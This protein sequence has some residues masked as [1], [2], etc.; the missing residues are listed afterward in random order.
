[1]RLILIR[2]GQ[3]EASSA[4]GS[5]FRRALT[6]AGRE[7]LEN[8][9]PSLARYLNAKASCEV[10]TSPKTRALQTAEVLCRYMPDVSPEI[11]PFLENGDLDAFADA[12]RS[13]KHGDT[14]VVI[15]HEPYLSDWV[16]AMTGLDVHFKKGCGEML[17]LPP[18]APERA[19]RIAGIDFDQMKTLDLFS[20]PVGVGI[21]T[22]IERQHKQIVK[23]RD[24]FL[25]D[26]DDSDALSALRVALRSQYALLE[27][28]EPYCS[29]KP[30]R[31]AERLYLSLYDD[32]EE[33]RAIN[34]ILK[35][36]HNSRKLELAVLADAIRSHKHGD[37][38]V[39]IGHEPY[40]SDWV[41][42]MT[43]LDVH[44]K[45][46]CGEM[47]Y[48][49]PHAPERAIRIAGIDFDQM[50]TLDLF[51]VP[52]GVGIATLIERQ[53]KQIVKARDTFLDDPDDSDAL[54][55][56][57]VALRSQY[58][59]LEFIE[60]YCSQKPFRKAERLY[61]SLYD[62]LEE[63]RA[64]NAIL[65]TIHNSRKLELAV[66]ADAMVVEQNDALM[67]LCD[68]LSREDSEEDYNEALHQTIAVLM[69]AKETAPLEILVREQLSHRYRLVLDAI[70]A[71][72]FNDLDAIEHL[73]SLCK[74][75]RY[76]FE[77]FSPLADYQLAQQYLRIRRLNQRLSIYC[78]TFY[79]I[80]QLQERLSE[81][82]N[83]LV[84]RAMRL[85]TQMMR[86]S[87]QA[88]MEVVE[89]LIDEFGCNDAIDDEEELPAKKKA[90]KKKAQK[91]PKEKKK[92]GK[93][94]EKKKQ[95]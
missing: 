8:A 6:P 29:Q 35:T 49:P 38:L 37:T 67:T 82:D 7:R 74:T 34:A 44:F 13:H 61:L 40:L 86:Q 70:C 36:I 45:K 93:K 83:P 25:D 5:D 56:L 80:D 27:F 69:T 75:S 71:T 16:R 87:G 60:P 89:R 90:D 94:K 9:Y 63:L 48:L 20:V 62:D 50:K 26:P 76:L 19:I 39:V 73:R 14:L 33:L 24:T 31:K 15:G 78:D 92:D 18:H 65:K 66:L 72:D 32:L 59:L 58:A 68:H 64:I 23:A 41:R 79:N 30:F 43:G 1:M 51:S 91:P 81:D 52:V 12:I 47:L 3:A 22:L 57:R 85:Y 42:A 17:Y 88:Q 11:K 10:W 55:A 95:K 28:I 54:S 46:G 4:D 53:H 84:T 2:H 77:F 21:A